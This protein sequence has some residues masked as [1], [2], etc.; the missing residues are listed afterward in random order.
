M[1]RK[2]PLASRQPWSM[3]AHRAGVLEEVLGEIDDLPQKS[4]D[5]IV[6]HLEKYWS[7]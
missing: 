7:R 5:L 1:A 2:T 6:K 3:N 4:V